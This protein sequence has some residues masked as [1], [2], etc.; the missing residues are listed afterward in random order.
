MRERFPINPGHGAARGFLRVAGP[1]VL[2]IGLIFAIVG[3]VDFFSAFGGSGPP[4]K[5]WCLFVGMPLIF[6]GLVMTSAGF[7]GAMARYSAQ[8]NAPVGVDTFNYAARNT[9]QGVRQIAGA[10]GAGLRDAGPGGGA[11]KVRCHKCNKEND[12]DAKFCD[13]CGAALM[14][15]A[16]CPGCGELNDPD[17]RYCDNCGRSLRGG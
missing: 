2:I 13:E 15:S 7:M 11:A 10:I 1:V 9:Q 8:E 6:V 5:F 16:A 12:A 17:A 3:L 14:K 4:T